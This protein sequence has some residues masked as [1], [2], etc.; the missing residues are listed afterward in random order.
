MVAYYL[1]PNKWLWCWCWVL[2]AATTDPSPSSGTEL[3]GDD[4]NPSCEQT[5]ARTPGGRPECHN[6]QVRTVCCVY[7]LAKPTGGKVRIKVNCRP[8]GNGVKNINT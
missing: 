1:W 3:R 8:L 5:A 4:L 6:R 2:V 7:T